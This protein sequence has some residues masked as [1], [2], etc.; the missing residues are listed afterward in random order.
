MLMPCLLVI[1]IQERA[2][3]PHFNARAVKP[4]ENLRES[5]HYEN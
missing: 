1:R 4:V 5:F 2:D 3:N